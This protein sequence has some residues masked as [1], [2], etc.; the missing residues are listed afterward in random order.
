MHSTMVCATVCFTPSGFG[1][2][3]NCTS[4]K[5]LSQ[6]EE[7]TNEIAYCFIFSFEYGITCLFI[8]ASN[9]SLKEGSFHFASQLQE[10]EPK[11]QKATMMSMKVHVSSL[12]APIYKNCYLCVG[13]KKVQTLRCR[14][15]RKS[16]CANGSVLCTAAEAI[17]RTKL[18]SFVWQQKKFR[19][20]PHETP[21]M[22][23]VYRRSRRCFS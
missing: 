5:I 19:G 23:V 15:T 8:H 21:T 10:K 22:P 16:L 4:A 13:K 11:L 2:M 18:G 7:I 1:P 9:C 12:H 6:S 20:F 3:R 17:A 14:A